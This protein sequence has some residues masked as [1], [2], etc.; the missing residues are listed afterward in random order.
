MFVKGRLNVVLQDKSTFYE[1]PNTLSIKSNIMPLNLV[2][3]LKGQPVTETLKGETIQVF[4][5]LNSYETKGKSK[6]QLIMITK[7]KSKMT[8]YDLCRVPEMKPEVF[9]QIRR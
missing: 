5:A 9:I 3:F 4:I 6:D 1:V 7:S 2:D 8:T